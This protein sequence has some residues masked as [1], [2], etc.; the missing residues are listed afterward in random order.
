MRIKFVKNTNDFVIGIA[1]LA[2]GIYILLTKKIVFGNVMQTSGGPLVHPEVYVRLLGGIL[3]FLAAILVLKSLNWRRSAEL[4]P[5]R[6]LITPHIFLT[7]VAL[8]L[9]TFL[10]PR[11]G[12]AVYL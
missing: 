12:F 10:L 3:T 11:I 5:F 4:T 1:L 7:V 6:F 2:L 9:Y 8:V